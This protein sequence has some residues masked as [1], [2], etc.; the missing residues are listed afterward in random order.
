MTNPTCKTC[1]YWSLSTTSWKSV[2]TV[3]VESAY[4]YCSAPGVVY[5]YHPSDE[6]K[7]LAL[8]RVEDDEGWGMLTR[9][10]FGCVLHQLKLETS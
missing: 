7:N 4:R 9:E 1:R 5:G 10:D 8:V 2:D 3:D 6:E